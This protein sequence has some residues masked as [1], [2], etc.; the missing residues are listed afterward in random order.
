[1]YVIAGMAMVQAVQSIS[2]PHFTAIPRQSASYKAWALPRPYVIP[3]RLLRKSHV[4]A[5]NPA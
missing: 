3:M 4:I 2:V 5:V 1:M